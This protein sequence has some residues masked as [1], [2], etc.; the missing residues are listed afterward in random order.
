MTEFEKGIDQDVMVP[1][2]PLVS[3]HPGRVSYPGFNPRR[4][5][6]DGLVIERDVALQMRD[7]TTLY[8]D[9]FRPD[10]VDAALPAIVVWSAYGKHTRWWSLPGADIDLAALSPHTVFECPDPVPLCERGYAYV[11][12][13]PRGVCM[14]EGDISV[15]TPQEGEDMYDTIEWVAAQPWC[16]GKV[17]MTGASYYGWSQW[18]AGSTCPPHLDALIIYDGLS[19]PYRE[20]AFHGG[21]PNNKFVNFWE[22]S[23]GVSKNRREDWVKASAIHPLFDEYW[24]AKVAPVER[25]NV[26]LFV[27]SS[28][29]DHGIH[30]RGTLEGYKRTGSDRKWLEVHGRKKWMWMYRPETVGRQVAFFDR[31]LKGT[32]NEVDS[33]PAVRLEV[34]ERAN[35][36]TFRDEQE[37]P[38]KRTVPTPFYLGRRHPHAGLDAVKPCRRA[39]LRRDGD[40]HQRELRA[41]VF[42]GHRDYGTCKIAPVGRGG[43]VR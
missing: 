27:V 17:A 20:L 18:R 11:A 34:R 26:P 42:R 32:P 8:A 12:V 5:R 21:I 28:W 14:S 7:G 23:V 16:V 31:F 22:K 10:G 38:L 19:D 30:T 36:G 35:V 33:W 40:P 6:A 37:W 4:E 9:I 24:Q 41:R 2:L 29:A 13:D 15:F 39:G 1:G 43:G 25:M 3:P